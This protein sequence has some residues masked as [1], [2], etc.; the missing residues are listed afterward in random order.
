M[1]ADYLLG[2]HIKGD[3]PEVNL[4]VGVNAG[5]DEEDA[6]TLCTSRPESAKPEDDCSFILLH[7]LDT[8]TEG[9]GEGDHHHQQGQQGQQQGTASWTSRVS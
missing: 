3:R 6:W 1:V 5:D 7:H 8:E 2:R 4:L 9:Y